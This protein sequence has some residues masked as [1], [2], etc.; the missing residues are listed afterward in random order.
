M[1][2]YQSALLDANGNGL[3]NEQED[4]D[5]L[6]SMESTIYALRRQYNRNDMGKPSIAIVTDDQTLNGGD[7]ANL[8]ARSVYDLNDDAITRVWAEIIPPDANPDSAQIQTD[9]ATVKLI[10][11]DE[12]GIYEGS[13][14]N[15]AVEGT[16]IVTYFAIDENGICSM[17]KTSLVTQLSGTASP[18][19][20]YEDDD[21]FIDSQD[22]V[23]NNPNLQLHTFHESG[24]TDWVKFYALAG[25]TYKIRTSNLTLICDTEIALYDTDGT[26]S[27][28]VDGHSNPDNYLYVRNGAGKGDSLVW[29]CLYDGVYYLKLTNTTPHYGANVR[30]ELQVYEPAASFY[31]Q[32]Q[33][34][35]IV[36][37]EG[38]N[39]IIT[40][41]KIETSGVVANVQSNGAYIMFIEPGSY[42]LTSNIEGYIGESQNITV[43]KGSVLT[44]IDFTIAVDPDSDGDTIADSADNCPATANPDQTDSDSDNFGDACDAFENDPDEWSDT[45][46]DGTGDNADEDDDNDGMSDVAENGPDGNNHDYD[47]NQDGIADNLQDNVSSFHTYDNQKYITLAAPVDVFLTNCQAADNPS[48]TDAPADME[49]SYGFFD[50]TITGLDP[51]GS[52]TLTMFLPTDEV[53]KTYYKYGKTPAKQTDHWYK[54]LFDGQTGA[55]INA[56]VITLHFTDAKRGDDELNEDSIIID[57]GGPG[58]TVGNNN[59]DGGVSG[60]G[61]GGCFISTINK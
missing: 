27:P 21:T 58:F 36:R 35:G 45:D 23:P 19:D 43:A 12:D 48:P 60:S 49:F 41:G 6:A 37:R 50:F 46:G 18:P 11:L 20:A 54:F 10:D 28:P 25:K 42:T 61:G 2:G 52:T 40:S 57:L 13:Y 9:I 32:G 44:G 7:S 15:F 30:Y 1:R 34:E 47:G 51:G 56:N 31:T 39:A 4:Q 26:T 59:N 22:I 29:T 53:P 3:P 5:A 33:V 24:D 17:P 38:D 8:M 55:E 16:Y 14:I